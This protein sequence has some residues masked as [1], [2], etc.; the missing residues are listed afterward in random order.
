MSKK[1]WLIVKLAVLILLFALILSIM[2]SMLNVDGLDFGFN[3]GMNRRLDDGIPTEQEQNFEDI[4]RIVFYG[5]SLPLSINET[6]RDDVLLI[7]NTT[8]TGNVEPNQYLV[9]GNTLYFEQGGFRRIGFN[10]NYDGISGEIK[11]EVPMGVEIEYDIDSVSGG[12]VVDAPLNNGLKINNVSGNIDILQGGDELIINSVSGKIEIEEPVITQKIATVSGGIDTVAD[13]ESVEID[14]D[15]VSGSTDI[16]LSEG[17]TYSVKHAAVS[18][19]VNDDYTGGSGASDKTLN[20][21]VSSVSGSVNIF[22]D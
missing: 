9:E 14:V 20:I 15:S 18:G 11:F 2:V 10:F 16:A 7:D 13:T 4:E 5:Y 12:I 19:S 8:M 1:N 17:V 21:S 6:Q 22:D 3:L